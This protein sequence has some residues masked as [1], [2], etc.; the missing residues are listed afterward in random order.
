MKISLLAS[1]HLLSACDSNSN[2]DQS[3]TPLRWSDQDLAT[4]AA[5]EESVVFVLKP[6]TYIN[7]E[8]N[9]CSTLFGIASISVADATEFKY[10][11]G[12]AIFGAQ[13]P[14]QSWD[15]VMVARPLD[16][17]Y[18]YLTL[19]RYGSILEG[20]GSFVEFGFFD[21]L[22]NAE[23]Y[24]TDVPIFG[25]ERTVPSDIKTPFAG[26]IWGNI[27]EGGRWRDTFAKFNPGCSGEWYLRNIPSKDTGLNTGHYDLE[28]LPASEFNSS[29]ESCAVFYGEATVSQNENGHLETRFS[30]QPEQGIDVEFVKSTA[31]LGYQLSPVIQSYTINGEQKS[32]TLQMGMPDGK[33]WAHSN[34]CFGYWIASEK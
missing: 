5:T 17:T 21:S 28:F 8:G 29:G 10:Q 27:Y 20:Q 2:S 34:G 16:I 12:L 22:D 4:L 33:D 6:D 7:E 1:L 24:W 3:T 25:S 31:N 9:R 30:T 26:D 18:V 15:S 19:D 32:L 23:T 11:L 13:Q 14:V